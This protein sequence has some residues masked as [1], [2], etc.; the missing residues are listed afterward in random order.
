MRTPVNIRLE[1]PRLWQVSAVS[2]LL[3]VK[4]DLWSGAGSA[5]EASGCVGSVSV[6]A[7]SDGYQHTLAGYVGDM[8]VFG[9]RNGLDIAASW[10]KLLTIQGWER[11][12][13]GAKEPAPGAEGDPLVFMR[14][15]AERFR[16]RA[17]DRRL[18][19]A[20]VFAESPA[21][22]SELAAMGGALDE[23]AED[24][25]REISRAAEACGQTGKRWW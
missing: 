24:L 19:A 15:L 1:K 20:Q 12:E 22:A 7:V 6:R 4:I 16:E 13:P 5:Y 10:E 2:G 14:K 21:R 3:P 8:Q 18:S 9:Y 17:N 23:A 25:E 11:A